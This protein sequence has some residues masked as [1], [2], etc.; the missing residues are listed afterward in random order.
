MEKAYAIILAG[1]NGERFWPLSTT[2]RPKQFVDVFGGKP[3]IRHAFDRLE[4]LIP[5]ENVLVI[6]AERLV[7]QTRRALPMLPAGNIIGE[8]CRRDTAAAVAVAVGLVRRRGGANAVGC[9]L[10]ADHVMEPAAAFRRTLCAAIGAAAKTNAIVTLGIAPTRPETGFGYIE[11]GEP[12]ETGTRVAFR[13]VRR[14][15]EKPNLQAARRYLRTRRFYW[16]SGMFIW[17]AATME[18]AY[19]QHAPD[20]AV[21]ID[22]V[23]GA[24]SVPSALRRTYPGLRAISVDFAVMEKAKRILVA[25]CDFKWDDVGGW[26]ALPNHFPADADGNTRLGKTSVLDTSGSIL[27][28]L[29]GRVTAAIGVTDIVVV[30]SDAGTL[31]CAKDRLQDVKRLLQGLA[32]PTAERASSR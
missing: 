25:V 12:V 31:V 18:A 26:L 11:V 20:L 30:Q 9:I 16:N 1:G 7:A 4:G 23:A 32:A 15:V 3:L 24:R 5:V 2:E 22:R 29:N 10:T 13:R 17:S 27:V 8:P 21:L 14:F 6:T 19:R 28:S